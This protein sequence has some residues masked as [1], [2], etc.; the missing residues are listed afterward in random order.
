MLPAW[1]V[2]PDVW[3][4]LVGKRGWSPEAF[5]KWLREAISAQLLKPRDPR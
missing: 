5:E 1:H 2:H 3:L 4:L